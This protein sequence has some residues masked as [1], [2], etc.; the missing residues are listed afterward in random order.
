MIL[1]ALRAKLRARGALGFAADAT[2]LAFGCFVIG[3]YQF[4][5]AGGA[6]AGVVVSLPLLA[7]EILAKPRAGER[8][9]R[10]DADCA[11]DRMACGDGT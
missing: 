10:C 8:A 4:A 7:F 1:A 3:V 5:L 2:E 9:H 6:V 11:S